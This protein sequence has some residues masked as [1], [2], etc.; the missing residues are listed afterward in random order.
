MPRAADKLRE[1]IHLG[2]DVIEGPWDG[3]EGITLWADLEAGCTGAMTGG[4][5]PDGMR[6][7]NGA[8]STVPLAGASWIMM[9][10]SIASDTRE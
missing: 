3:E 8:D 1:L 10:M 9:G 5:F 2:G 6:A 7:R 4:G